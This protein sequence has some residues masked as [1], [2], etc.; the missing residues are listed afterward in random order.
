M[1]ILDFFFVFIKQTD[2]LDEMTKY[3]MIPI[4]CKYITIFHN[5]H[6]DV[7]ELAFFTNQL[8]LV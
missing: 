4:I 8:F 5:V 6:E 7:I 2:S 3:Q 1:D